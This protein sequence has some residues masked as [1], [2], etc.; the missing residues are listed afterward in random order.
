M[1]LLYLGIACL[2][3]ALIAGFFGFYNIK[4]TAVDIAKILFVLFLALFVLS[5][6]KTYLL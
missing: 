2:V 6:V 3:I 4:H 1:D 5:L